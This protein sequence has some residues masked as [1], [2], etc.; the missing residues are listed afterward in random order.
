MRGR[1]WIG[2]AAGVALAIAG[3]VA[4]G[5]AGASGG[6]N[7]PA[8]STLCTD[9]LRS[10][11]GVWFYGHV[12]DPRTMGE[13][14]SWTVLRSTAL[15][16]P[17]TEI[18]R[19]TD[20]ELPTHYLDRGQIGTFYY[21]ACVVVQGGTSDSRSGVAL[22]LGPWPQPL[23]DVQYDIGPSTATLGPGA[24]YCDDVALGDRARVVGSASVP[25]QWY[26][27]GINED[28]ASV[29]NAWVGPVTTSIDQVNDSTRKPVVE[30]SA[31]VTN[32]SSTP[33]TVSFELSQP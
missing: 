17:E 18:L 26:F 29:T 12:Y 13:T 7:V 31:C 30:L 21:R 15:G 2:L 24:K 9:T 32:V 5:P 14:G 4:A 11:N 10:G 33:A 1:R 23:V 6:G 25:V 22:R 8:G 3:V 19:A 27:N 28:Y 16:G 20:D